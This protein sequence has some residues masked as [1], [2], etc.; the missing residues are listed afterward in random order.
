VAQTLTLVER[1][2]A[3]SQLAALSQYVQKLQGKEKEEILR[4]ALE[5]SCFLIPAMN[6]VGYFV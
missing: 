4:F 1:L 2:I 5:E 3:L 6:E